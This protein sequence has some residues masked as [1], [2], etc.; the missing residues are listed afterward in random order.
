MKKYLS[1]AMAILMTMTLVACGGEEQNNQ[2]VA[3]VV[4]GKLI[5]ATEAGFAPYEYM[6]GDEV[7]GV[8]MDIAK[9]I[10]DKLGVELE[11]ANMDFDACVPAVQ[12][13]KADI[14][15]AGLSISPERAEQVD[16]SDMYVNS[17]EV[18]VVNANAPAVTEATSNAIMD[19]IVA[20]QQGNMADFWVTDLGIEPQRY[21]KFAQA[22][23]DLKNGRIDCIVMDEAPANEL[24]A[25]SDGAL[26]V[27]AGDPLFEDA[28]AAA[29]N[30]ENAELLK[31]VNEV[32]NE[33]KASG[34][35][36][37]I[38]AAHVSA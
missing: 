36:D 23:E 6:V 2:A 25:G 1:L 14:V 27:I 8:D 19:K 11:I 30:K 20:V 13:G 21:T 3:T 24:V 16:F 28:Y 33:L 5:V 34:K 7:V 31:I 15:L 38:M 37:E 35:M 17:K 18:V 22:G 32:I 4:P 26:I 12:S 10:A 29:V 9:A